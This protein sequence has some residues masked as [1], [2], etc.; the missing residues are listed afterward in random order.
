MANLKLFKDL[1]EIYY[2]RRERG[3]DDDLEEVL[4]EKDEEY[5]TGSEL[6]AHQALDILPSM[7]SHLQL[8]EKLRLTRE[9]W[10]RSA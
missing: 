2:I 5:V 10:K 9:R 1:H 8:K 6:K 4:L 7:I 3:E